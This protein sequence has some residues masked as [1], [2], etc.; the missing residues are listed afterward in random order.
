[1]DGNGEFAGL[2]SKNEIAFQHDF[3]PGL[4]RIKIRAFEEHA[5]DQNAKMML[6]INRA[7]VQQ[8]DVSARRNEPAVYEAPFKTD[9]G[10]Q[11][12]AV[13]FENDFYV[14]ANPPGN[15][16]R[17][18]WIDSI[19]IHGPLGGTFSVPE[20]HRKIIPG[21]PPPGKS[22]DYAR[23][24]LTNFATRAYRRPTSTEEIERLLH[25]YD[26][27]IKFN[28][29]FERGIQLGVQAILVSP[30]FLFRAEIDPKTNPTAARNLNGY[31][32]ATRLSYFLWSSMPDDRLFALAAD[33]SLSKPG[34]MQQ[35]VRR[36]LKDPKSKALADNFA[37]QWLTLRKLSII[38]PDPKQ[39]PKFTNELKS[40]M[41]EETKSFF[42]AVVS[43]DRSVLDFIDG[44]FTYINGPLAQHYGIPN[45]VGPEFRKVSLVGTERGGILTQASVLT[46]TSNPTR[47]SPTKRG[48]WVLE[49]I[50]GTPP[51]P[52]PP[53][54]DVLADEGKTVDGKTL[55]E[56]MIA[57]R[58]KPEC[59]SCHSKMDPLGFGLEN[60]DPIGGWRT[61][62]SELKVDAS[63]ELPD[64][65]KFT[66]PTQLRAL[67]MKD[68]DQF[69][70]SLSEKLLTYAL[71][72]GVDFADKCHVD[73]I[74][75]QTAKSGYKFSALVNA[76]VNS[77]PFKKR[78]T[79]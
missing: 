69:V 50:L 66:G 4:Y 57:H 21:E 24:V 5:G 27:A 29:P 12:V 48:R 35:E 75:Q 45:V 55:R 37:S 79:K 41:V 33:G 56:K 20:S 16:D 40:A 59:A 32:L 3:R 67:L 58:A 49:Q 19:E 47:T 78:R 7:E 15:R 53:G 42:N 76:V 63:G 72:R 26:L 18:L 70:K 46:V 10:R 60:F 17:N 36:M 54:V 11:R 73:T 31:E 74:A 28:E 14:A 77:D 1:A 64:G 65:T 38:N 51:P 39:F 30:N 43:G 44:K 23:R 22:R 25:I 61:T 2:F 6:R 8:F 34:V 71:G 52:P 13:G 62:E 68:K 9:G